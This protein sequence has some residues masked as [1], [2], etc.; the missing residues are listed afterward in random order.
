MQRSQ[1]WMAFCNQWLR[2]LQ[3]SR[4]RAHPKSSHSLTVWLCIT[5]YPRSRSFHRCVTFGN[6]ST[7]PRRKSNPLST[8]EGLSTL[9]FV[10]LEFSLRV[11]CILHH[12]ISMANPTSSSTLAIEKSFQDSLNKFKSRL[13]NDERSQF[14]FTKLE[15][16]RQAAG[17]IQAEQGARSAAM[18]LPRIKGF[19]EAFTQFGTVIEVFL[20]ASEFVA[21]IWGPMKFLLQ[22]SILTKE[23][24]APFP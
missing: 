17:K 18:H 14:Q 8:G 11:E 20:N 13:T 16:L 23:R 15:D 19:L 4:I 5:M 7:G 21:F 10:S 22:V 24:T 2:K 9:A 12:L 3:L 6:F 1:A